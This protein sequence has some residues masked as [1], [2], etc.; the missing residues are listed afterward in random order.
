V[1]R[2][3]S[4]LGARS[5]GFS[6]ANCCMAGKFRRGFR[7][8]AR[9]SAAIPSEPWGHGVASSFGATKL[10]IWAE[11]WA[12]AK[13]DRGPRQQRFRNSRNFRRFFRHRLNFNPGRPRARIVPL[14]AQIAPC[15]STCSNVPFGYSKRSGTRFD[16]KAGYRFTPLGASPAGGPVPGANFPEIHGAGS[17]SQVR[18]DNVAE[19]APSLTR[20]D[21][22]P[23]SP[24]PPKAVRIEWK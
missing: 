5:C 19:S 12:G 1:P 8:S 20:V 9:K 7:P 4:P 2:L 11:K 16:C 6:G 21:P 23:R 15:A 17:C 18:E 10:H 14:C 3:S 24:L 13:V 22:C